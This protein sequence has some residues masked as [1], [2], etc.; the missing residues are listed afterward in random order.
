MMPSKTK[1]ILIGAVVYAVVGAVMAFV[2]SSGNFVAAAVAGCGGCLAAFAGPATAVWHYVS[3]YRLTL[4]AGAGA[5]LGAL[6]GLAGAVLSIVLTYVLRAVDV[7]PT[8]AEAMEIQREM[9]IAAGQD[10][11]AVDAQLEAGAA[12]SGPVFEVGVGLLTG[13]IVGAIGGAIAAAVFKRGEN[14]DDEV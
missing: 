4:P 12:L 6:T 11:A 8:A 14:E 2:A 7:L 10:A 5:G 13:L 3:T 1:S 9:L